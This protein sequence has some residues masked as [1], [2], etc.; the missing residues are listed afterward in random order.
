M[1]REWNEEA[2]L[3]CTHSLMLPF[4]V[5]LHLQPLVKFS[6]SCCA[7]NREALR[8][9]LN[10]SF[11]SSVVSHVDSL[12]P[13]QHLSCGIVAG[14]AASVITQPADVIKTRMQLQPKAYPSLPATIANIIRSNGVHGMFT[15]AVPRAM[16]RTLMAAFTWAFYEEVSS[17][18]YYNTAKVSYLNGSL[19]LIHYNLA[20]P[21]NL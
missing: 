7:L 6:V 5:M 4:P 10:P 1:N 16:R 9:S 3:L 17:A 20:S 19:I 11:L 2:P 21:L 15:G 13:L 14:F 18:S 8:V 12:S